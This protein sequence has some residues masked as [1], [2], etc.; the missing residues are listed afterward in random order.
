MHTVCLCNSHIPWGGG[1]TWHL[2]AARS[3]ALRGWRVL[4][5]CH[6]A[7]ELMRRVSE[8]PGVTAV[9]FPIS[10]FSF[11]NPLV[12]VRL[13]NFFREEQVHALIMNLPQDLKSASLPARIA[14]VKHI[15]YRRGSALPVR[16]SVLNRRLYGSVITRLIVNSKATRDMA[17]AGRTDF[18]PEDRISILPNGIDIE[19]FDAS[20]EAAMTARRESAIGA[21]FIGRKPFVIGNAGRLNRQK[22]QHLLLHLTRR[23]LDAGLDC[24]LII[25]GSG[26]REEELKRLAGQLNLGPRALFPGFMAD[27]GPFWAGIDLFVLSSLWEGFGNVIIEA[28]LAQKPVF[29]FNVSNLP[30]LVLDGVNGRLFTLPEEE[31][32]HCPDFPPGEESSGEV[33]PRVDDSAAK[34]AAEG[35]SRREATEMAAEAK[36]AAIARS[37]LEKAQWAKEAD[38]TRALRGPYITLNAMVAAVQ[39][40]AANPRDAARMGMAGRRLA[41]QYS[42]DACMDELEKLLE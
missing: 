36:A 1:E 9:P 30:E 29:A 19:A 3:L 7:G 41:L 27:M 17:L 24:R 38:L 26:D 5:L 31:R 25:A 34:A 23:L 28:G 12:R 2:N 42:Q 14:G 16:D 40:L 18:I 15:I 35:A 4:V 32:P 22:G 21:S 37:A 39:E 33:L 11:L 8:V 10:R 6:P 13:I 20:L